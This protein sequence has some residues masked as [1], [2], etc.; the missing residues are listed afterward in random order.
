M[1]PQAL[2]AIAHDAFIR[3]AVVDPVPFGIHDRDHVRS[4]LSDQPDEI[5]SLIQL[6][7]HAA[8]L[9]LR[10]DHIYIEQENQADQ[11]AHSETHVQ[12]AE[13]LEGQTRPRKHER[14]DHQREEEGYKNCGSQ[15]PPLAPFDLTHA[16][17][18]GIG[19]TP[20]QWRGGFCRRAF[21]GS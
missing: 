16:K 18:R 21:D 20:G 3:G 5:V 15:Q 19:C 7:S 1:W 9:I 13:V 12:P 14:G 2:G 8:N 6:V 4:F 17:V 10:V 11:S